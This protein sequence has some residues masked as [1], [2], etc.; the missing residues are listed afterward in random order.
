MKKDI[1]LND[2]EE[3]AN[4]KLYMRG[5]AMIP[6]RFWQYKLININRPFDENDLKGFILIDLKAAI[7]KHNGVSY[8]LLIN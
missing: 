3:I 7:I 8:S 4:H 2:T 5:N 6:Q 1:T